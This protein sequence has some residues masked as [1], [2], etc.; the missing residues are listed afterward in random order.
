MNDAP[1]PV[2]PLAPVYYRVTPAFW[3]NRAWTDD[4]RLLGLYLLTS[5]HRSLEGLFWLPQP[6]VLGDLQWSAERL[7]E[8]FAGLLLDRFID[9]DETV[10]VVFITKALKYQSPANDNMAAAAI[11]RLK[12]VPQSRLDVPF[13]ASCERYCERLAERL[14]EQLPER[15]GEPLLCSTSTSTSPQRAPAREAPVDNSIATEAAED[16]K[17]EHLPEVPVT[18]CGPVSK[19]VGAK[20]VDEL[21]AEGTDLNTAVARYLV[22]VDA[23]ADKTLAELS[24]AKRAELRDRIRRAAFDHLAAVHKVKAIANLPAYLTKVGRSA[25]G[26]SGLIDDALLDELRATTHGRRAKHAEPRRVSEAIPEFAQ[27]ETA[28]A[29]FPPRLP[30]QESVAS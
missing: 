6:Y 28:A 5:P 17:E 14:H 21:L 9:Y 26:L 27:E 18:L 13:L 1:K 15:F 2:K 4:M 20:R 25:T 10:E 30:A 7:A 22:V 19:I 23:M 24:P 12:I 3:M 16:P 8:P 11:K 29:S